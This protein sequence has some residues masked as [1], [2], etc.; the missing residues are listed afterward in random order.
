M[1]IE[2]P[3]IGNLFHDAVVRSF[4]ETRC[5]PFLVLPEYLVGVVNQH[6]ANVTVLALCD[7]DEL[8][9]FQLFHPLPPGTLT[10]GPAVAGCGNQDCSVAHFHD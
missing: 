10:R 8:Q 4:I 3:V 5:L 9:L 7:F 1:K 2:H 6:R